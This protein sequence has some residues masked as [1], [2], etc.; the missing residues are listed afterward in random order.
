MQTH[1]QQITPY[2]QGLFRYNQYVYDDNK[3]SHAGSTTRVANN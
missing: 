2:V 1:K 3:Q